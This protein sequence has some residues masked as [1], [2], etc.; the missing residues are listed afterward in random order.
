[1]IFKNVL[2]FCGWLFNCRYLQHGSFPVI[3][4]LNE[5]FPSDFYL[6]RAS[7]HNISIAASNPTVIHTIE[8]PLPGGW[9]AVA[10]LGDYIDDS[11]S[12]AV[13][14][15]LQFHLHEVKLP[16]L[17]FGIQFH[18]NVYYVQG[19][20]PDCHYYMHAIHYSEILEVVEDI[21]AND[22]VSVAANNLLHLYR[23][24]AIYVSIT[25]H[26]KPGSLTQRAVT[27]GKLCIS[28]SFVL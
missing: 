13:R 16:C 22:S 9:F 2:L 27:A 1:M 17:H 6:Q 5:T 7:L 21:Q 19:L 11:I 26:W 23:F 3:S 18:H 10:Y 25:K 24:V 28:C 14:K 4:P 15:N 20:S 8:S 12:Q